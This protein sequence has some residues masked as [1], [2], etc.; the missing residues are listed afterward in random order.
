MWQEEICFSRTFLL[1]L[2]VFATGELSP[3]L[4]ENPCP[5]AMGQLPSVGW[6]DK[7]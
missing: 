7:G 4:L 3:G 1:H 6:R 5:G 2:A